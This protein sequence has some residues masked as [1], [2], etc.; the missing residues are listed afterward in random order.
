MSPVRRSISTK[1]IIATSANAPANT[2]RIAER[3]RNP[4]Y[5][6]RVPAIMTSAPSEPLARCARRS[7]IALIG[8]SDES[9][10]LDDDAARDASISQHERAG[11]REIG[12]QQGDR[13]MNADDH[14]D[15]ADRSQRRHRA[16]G[17]EQRQGATLAG[18]ARGAEVGESQHHEGERIQRRRD[19]VMKLGAESGPAGRRRTA[20]RRGPAGTAPRDSVRAP[21]T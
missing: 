5:R 21:S 4:K 8:L 17:G 7:T 19:A 2:A 18:G 14:G 12:K 15:E 16:D 11:Q 13:R 3:K 9:R 1:S 20:D 6:D 10:R